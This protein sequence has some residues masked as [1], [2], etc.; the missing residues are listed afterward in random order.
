MHR[1]SLLLLQMIAS[2]GQNI[3]EEDS[4]NSNEEE[5]EDEQAANDA[6]PSEATHEKVHTFQGQSRT[7]LSR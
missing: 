4:E 1:D 7:H 6:E 3:S 5:S 2:R